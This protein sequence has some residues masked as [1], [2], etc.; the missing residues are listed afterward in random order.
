ME[1]RGREE[2]GSTSLRR[3]AFSEQDKRGDRAKG[4]W[5]YPRHGIPCWLLR[6]CPQQ[7]PRTFPPIQ[8]SP[9][10]GALPRG[11]ARAGGEPRWPTEWNR[12]SW[13]KGLHGSLVHPPFLHR[14]PGTCRHLQLSGLE[15]GAWGALDNLQ[16]S[17][18]A[19]G[20]PARTATKGGNCSLLLSLPD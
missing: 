10:T 18:Y 12:W 15:L 20:F 16:N 11:A 8:P 3:A 7:E 13:S 1:E 19:L 17:D 6:A 5:W 14:L 2:L 9:G 4:S